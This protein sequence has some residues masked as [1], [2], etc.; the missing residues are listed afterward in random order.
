MI[1]KNVIDCKYER[2]LDGTLLCELLHPQH[3]SLKMNFSLA[4][5]ILKPGEASLPHRLKESMEVYYILEGEGIMHIDDETKKV[6]MG[7]AIYIPAKAVQYIENS[8]DS[9]LS[10]LCVVSPPW[11]RKNEEVL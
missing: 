1:V 7:D 9:M 6:R 11:R 8:G 4:H 10:F 3:E 2:V 5:A